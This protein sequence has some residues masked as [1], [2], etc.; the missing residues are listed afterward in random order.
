MK[1][2][3]LLLFLLLTINSNSFGNEFNDK[4]IPDDFREYF[5]NTELILKILID[6][7]YVVDAIAIVQSNGLI[8]MVESM[9]TMLSEEN[10]KHQKILDLLLDH[11]LMI[12]DCDDFSQC[13]GF[14]KN[15][16]F[17]I[18]NSS[19]N[20]YTEYYEKDSVKSYYKPVLDTVPSGAILSADL[21]FN[22]SSEWTSWGGNMEIS[23]SLLNW[24]HVLNVRSNGVVD[25]EQS[26]E[27][28]E[29]Y[30]Q[31]LFERSYV[32]VG[33]FSSSSYASN[34]KYSSMSNIDMLGVMWGTSDQYFN[35]EDSVSL[36]P[37]YLQARIGSIAEVW[38]DGRLIYTQQLQPGLQALDTRKLPFGIYDVTIDIYEN[39]VRAESIIA[40][41]YKPY[42]WVNN[43]SFWRVNLF[44]G[45]FNGTK[46]DKYRPEVFGGVFDVNIHPRLTL[47]FSGNLMPRVEEYQY[48]FGA[49]Y[50]V[51][52]KES[53]FLS[54]TTNITPRWE[55]NSS[56][57]R[58]F[59]TISS[60]LNIS[61]HYNRNE[62]QN[63]RYLSSYLN[64]NVGF[65]SSVRIDESS[66][67][68]LEGGVVKNDDRTGLYSN[69]LFRKSFELQGYSINTTF[70]AY[71]RLYLDT[72]ER[73]VSLNASFNFPTKNR[74]TAYSTI[75]QSGDSRYGVFGVSW[76]V[77]ELSRLD[78]SVS[79][80]DN[81]K[82]MSVSGGFQTN[83]MDSDFF[84]SYYVNENELNIGGN[85]RSTIVIGRNNLLF[86][87]NQA[88]DSALIV[89]VN[90]D[91]DDDE[92][93]SAIS[94]YLDI[95]IK[96][97]G[98]TVVPIVPWE[99]QR[100]NFVDS[101]NLGVKFIPSMIDLELGKGSID[102]VDVRAVKVYTVVTQ[103][104]DMDNKLLQNFYVESDVDKVFV[105]GDG[106]LVIETSYMN[107]QFVVMHAESAE[108]Y[109]CKFVSD[110][111][112]KQN[113]VFIESISC[114]INS[115]GK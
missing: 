29:F 93:F 16:Y 51:S 60:N 112:T 64:E 96:G 15:V 89:N 10:D 48:G 57:I 69:L 39:N 18:N 3:S 63:H 24:N 13:L 41:I 84:G 99:S 34:V 59:H 22:K 82:I 5:F 100:I 85:V 54:K 83:E 52:D 38:K 109:H 2:Y 26:S 71:D 79:V 33:L 17:D 90:N 98:A 31:K 50:S 92:S 67:F 66:S 115:M 101:N 42:H 32:K 77:N 91:L 7:V 113:V 23:A 11:G 58:Y 74:H 87:Q 76:D 108:K 20:I 88:I 25:H 36:Q 75:G 49:T 97:G 35:V 68:M 45:V 21:S 80:S 62:L 44:G 86:T 72:K 14:I 53:V 105:N 95:P 1:Y 37:I 65:S 27:I 61:A 47:G 102:T 12:G 40:A 73:G 56:N 104:F 114:V 28:S 110:N 78:T 111:D 43:N 9:G 70:S 46:N 106:V 103:L 30:S 8:K 81:Q 19:V 107:N 4:H 6:D 94:S 55:S